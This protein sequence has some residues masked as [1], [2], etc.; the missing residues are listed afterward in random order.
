[1]KNDIKLAQHELAISYQADPWYRAWPQLPA[2]RLSD[3]EYCEEKKASPCI[4]NI[5][6]TGETAD[7][8]INLLKLKLGNQANC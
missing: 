4:D 1:V 5:L 6:N 7:I 8:R 3:T 2:N